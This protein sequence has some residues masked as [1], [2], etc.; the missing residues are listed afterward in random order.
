VIIVVILFYLILY[1]ISGLMMLK[2]LF[3]KSIS[4]LYRAIISI[5]ALLTVC[6]DCG[7]LTINAQNQGSVSVTVNTLGPGN[8]I[9]PN[10]M[11]YLIDMS[12][13][14]LLDSVLSNSQGKAIF[15]NVTGVENDSILTA[16]DFISR[17]YPNPTKKRLYFLMGWALENILGQGMIWDT[18]VPESWKASRYYQGIGYTNSINTPYIDLIHNTIAAKV[19]MGYTKDLIRL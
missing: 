12:N 9:A 15:N 8:V 13:N 4:F 5:L 11:V 10:T 16:T 1:K 6:F 7:S 14:M 17:N 2:V 18:S 3:N 19:R